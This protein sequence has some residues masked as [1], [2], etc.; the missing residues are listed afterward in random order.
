V[1]G[2]DDGSAPSKMKLYKDATTVDIN[3]MEE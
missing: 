1:I 3:I 2:G